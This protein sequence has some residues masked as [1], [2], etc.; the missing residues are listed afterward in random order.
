MEVVDPADCIPTALEELDSS[1]L[2]EIADQKPRINLLVPPSSSSRIT[3][4]ISG[5]FT[6]LR[7]WRLERTWASV[8][9]VGVL[10]GWVVFKR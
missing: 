10:V 3:M 4:D 1:P 7:E 2:I 6:W 9:F 5:L 8:G